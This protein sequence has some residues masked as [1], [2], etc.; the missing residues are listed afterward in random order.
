MLSRHGA[1]L[2]ILAALSLTF[3]AAPARAGEPGLEL[4]RQADRV[5]AVLGDRGQPPVARRQAV[6]AIVDDAFDFEEA[7]RRALGRAWAERT[8]YLA[9]AVQRLDPVKLLLSQAAIGCAILIVVSSI[10]EP[11]PT[12]W[13]PRLAAALA[14]QGG[15]IAGFCFI[16]NLWLLKR[17]R[18]SGLAAFFLTQ[19]IFGV[20]AA[21]IVTGDRLTPT[22]LIAC[23]AVAVGIG[24]STRRRV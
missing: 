22:L 10:A 13:T 5:I 20:V 18:P 12:R 2:A 9:K 23:A 8:V 1:A 4:Q 14:Y 6:R 16:V 19:P 15:L 21:A 17:Y 24:L 11:Q 7:A 3:S